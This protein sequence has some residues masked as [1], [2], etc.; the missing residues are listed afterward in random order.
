MTTNN[1]VNLAGEPVRE[2]GEPNAS[3]VAALEDLLRDAKEGRLQTFLGAGW[4][5]D[6]QRVSLFVPDYD[7]YFATL[8][9]LA[10]LTFEYQHGRGE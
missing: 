2:P 8:G 6:G 10:E 9:S 3:L 4:S 5:S 7:D 1:V